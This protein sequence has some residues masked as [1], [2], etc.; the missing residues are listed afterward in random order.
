MDKLNYNKD[1]MAKEHTSLLKCLTAEQLNVYKEIIS[2]FVSKNSI[3]F[4]L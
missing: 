4:F 3:F 1:E 2:S